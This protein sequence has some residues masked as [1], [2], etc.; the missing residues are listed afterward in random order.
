MILNVVETGDGPALVMLHGLMG[1]A[2][3]WGGL[4]KRLGQRHRVL[5]LD[6]RNHGASPHAAGMDYAAMAADVAETLAARG[7]TRAAVV[8][9]SMGGKTA[10][11]LA[12]TRPELVSRLVVADMAP[13]RY[14]APSRA[15]V[16]A[17]V[18]MELRP[19][20]TR[21]D[22]MTALEPA[23]PQENICAFLLQN[24]V[25]GE[26]AP[27]WRIGLA[28]IAAGMDAI[29]DFSPPP[30]ARYDPPA[31][32]IRGTRSDY[33]QPA[34]MGT[35]RAFFPAARHATLAAGHWVHSEDP[36]GF[37]A[38]VEPFLAEEVR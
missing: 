11:M 4:A 26:A 35:I 5:A 34:H 12:L 31:L 22:A 2:Q 10:M 14:A 33:V 29:E 17:M 37:L 36:G 7:I 20:M 27:R 25:F 13:V 38:L 15:Y 3:N 21:R 32:F 16:E 30:G 9:H 28:A 23:V 24:L 18:A 6:A 8:G 19:G 1:S